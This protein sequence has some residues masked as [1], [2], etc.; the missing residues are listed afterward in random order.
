MAVPG[1]AKHDRGLIMWEQIIMARWRPRWHTPWRTPV[2]LLRVSVLRAPDRG[3]PG[4]FCTGNTK[5][6]VGYKTF[7]QM[8]GEL[9]A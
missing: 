1:V 7:D 2:W 9:K 6:Y 4:N 8:A 3:G 5:G